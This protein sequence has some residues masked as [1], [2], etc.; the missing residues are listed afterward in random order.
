MKME[1]RYKKNKNFRRHFSNLIKGVENKFFDWQLIIFLHLKF[2]LH[3]C[4]QL[5]Y[6]LEK[7]YCSCKCHHPYIIINIEIRNEVICFLLFFN[8]KKKLCKIKL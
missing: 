3:H 2:L 4:S 1:Q 8:T 5:S 6:T 7:I